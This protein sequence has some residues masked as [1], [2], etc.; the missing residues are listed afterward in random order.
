M[1]GKIMMKK[2]D[3]ITLK[4]GSQYFSIVKN[5]DPNAQRPYS[6][7]IIDQ[8]REISLL[9]CTIV[10]ERPEPIRTCQQNTPDKCKIYEV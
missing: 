10:S 1:H 2:N 3:C 6:L 8:R 5:H 4:L 7:K 9:T